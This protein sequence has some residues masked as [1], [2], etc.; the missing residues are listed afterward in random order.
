MGLA[1]TQQLIARWLQTRV[2][3]LPVFDRYLDA[4]LEIGADAHL[5]KRCRTEESLATICRRTDPAETVEIQEGRLAIGI[6]SEQVLQSTE[7][8]I[9]VNSREEKG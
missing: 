3:L 1:S 2:V 5:L 9:L 6:E 7:I 8:G 4:A